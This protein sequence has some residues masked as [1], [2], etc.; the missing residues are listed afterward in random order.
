M[1]RR[2]D[3]AAAQPLRQIWPCPQDAV[4][5]KSFAQ[6]PTD[7]DSRIDQLNGN[8]MDLLPAPVVTKANVDDQ[9]LWANQVK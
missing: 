5:G 4:A 6:G 1:A 3:L 8:P 9:T 2:R 7:H